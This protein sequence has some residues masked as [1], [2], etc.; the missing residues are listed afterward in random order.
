MHAQETAGFIVIKSGHD[1]TAGVPE[2]EA[3]VGASTVRAYGNK[4]SGYA[5]TYLSRFITTPLIHIVSQSA[6]D[7][8]DGSWAVSTATQTATE[9][10]LVLDEDPNV[11][12]RHVTE[13]VSYLVLAQDGIIPLTSL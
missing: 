7:E 8:V 1:R 13:Q 4:A 6:M 9:L 11:N 3:R 12:R 10:G 5:Y 2:Y